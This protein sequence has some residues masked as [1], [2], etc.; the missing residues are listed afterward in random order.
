MFILYYKPTSIENIVGNSTTI[1]SILTWLN[2]WYI[3]GRDVKNTCALLSGPNGIGKTLTI[4]LIIQK[5]L[6]TNSDW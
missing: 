1:K 6:S 2:E 5:H 3:T 4:D